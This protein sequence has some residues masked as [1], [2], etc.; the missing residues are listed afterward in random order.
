METASAPVENR[1]IG[2]QTYRTGLYFLAHIAVVGS[3]VHPRAPA[4]NPGGVKIM[5]VLW[6]STPSLFTRKLEAALRFYRADFELCS[7]RGHPDGGQAEIRAGT[8]QV[9]L[10]QTPEN[11]VLA[12]TTPIIEM[13]DGRFP[14][15]RLFPPGPLGILTHLVEE[16]LDEWSARVMVHYRWHY[17]RSAK[18]A[19]RIISGG[20]EKVA[21]TVRGWGPRACRATGTE[22]EFHQRAAEA[23]YEALLA[24]A[25]LQLSQTRFLLGDR[26]TAADCIFL[27]GLWAHTL[28]DPDPSEVV[29][30]YPRVVAWA[31]EAQE[32]DGGG[33]W[34]TF[35]ESTAFARHVLAAMAKD[36]EPARQANAAAL[37]EGRKA[38]S[39]DTHGEPASYLT[40]EYP[41]QSWGLIR[42]RLER[43]SVTE[44]A[45]V[46][47]WLVAMGLTQGLLKTE[48]PTLAGGAV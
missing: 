12:D 13:L 1:N 35:P 24:A 7:K 14:A 36:Y 9:P 42:E 40:R 23:E 37:R 30:A 25:N 47:D 44:R 8:H 34:A 29:A 17:P 6:G 19:S 3:R 10:L 20:D 32:W 11:W 22:T 46:S 38:Y 15:R 5:Y 28:H 16:Y 4:S 26:P 48:P 27:G 21:E 45:E 43:L 18:F 39:V 33:R 41:Q 31:N 2:S